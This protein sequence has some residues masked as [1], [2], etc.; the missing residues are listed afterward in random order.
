MNINSITDSKTTTQSHSLNA[1]KVIMILFV[2]FIHTNPTVGRCGEAAMWWHSI[3]VVAVPVFFIISGYFFFYQTKVFGK[4]TYF[5]K[6]KKRI[7]T[8][9]IPYFLW[10]LLPVLL[11]TGGNFYSILFRGKSFD[12][13]KEFYTSLWDEGLYHIWWDKTSGT[14]PFDSPLWYVRDLMIVCILSPIIYIGIKRL[15]WIFPIIIG[16]LHLSGI[17]PQVNGFSSTAF[18]FFTIGATYALKDKLLIDLQA[19]AKIF[20]MT[21]TIICYLAAYLTYIGFIQQLFILLS[22]IL[23]ILLSVKIPDRLIQF[24]NKLTPAVFFIYAIHNTFVLA[25]TSKILLKIIDEKICFWISPIATMI[26][27]II[28]YFCIKRLFPKTTQ[29]ICGGR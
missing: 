7:R 15:G 6:L 9:L 17:W 28:M 19:S 29:F 25:N 13:L 12:A 10:N 20:L 18:C 5:K 21:A 22:A 8:L 27:C 1:L 3:N 26:I 4:E 11:I 16:L 2:I 23:W 14:M 24:M